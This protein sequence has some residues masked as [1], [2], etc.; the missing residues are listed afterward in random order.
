ML[1]M[2]KSKYDETYGISIKLS[3]VEEFRSYKNV[4][5]NIEQLV[6]KMTHFQVHH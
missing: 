4:V 3:N 2:D 5:E 6:I 1:E